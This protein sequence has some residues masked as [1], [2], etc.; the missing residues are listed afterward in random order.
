MDAL[1]TIK[2]KCIDCPL[3]QKECQFLQK[4]GTPKA[5][6]DRFNPTKNKFQTLPFECSL[7]G[8]CSAVCPV[9]LNPAQMFLEMRRIVVRLGGGNFPEYSPLLNYEK[10]GISKRYTY[11][12]FPDHCHTIFFPG[13][14]LAGTRPDK[15]LKVY[16]S[17]QKSIPNL[18]IVLDC[19][20]KP[21][22]DLG[23]ED[24][25]QAMFGEMKSHLV[26]KGIQTVLV[27]CPNCY[28]IFKNHGHPLL[29]RTIYEV[30][31]EI[32]PGST[33]KGLGVVTVHDPCV[34]RFEK[35][36]QDAV[37]ALIQSQGGTI[38]EM[39]HQKAKTICCGEGGAVGFIAPNL[40]ESW[41]VKIKS[42]A[43]GKTILT[44]CAGCANGLNKLTPTH[45]V[46]DFFYE[47]GATLSGKVKISQTLITYWN[48][49]RLKKRFR[50]IIPGGAAR[51]R[52]FQPEK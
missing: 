49:L 12:G 28:Q 13:C 19:C 11:Y 45:H 1:E 22:H 36:I 20:T 32:V 51:E 52:I 34:T 38:E 27:S 23:R 16:E 33:P 7:C 29:V 37:R 46:L 44:Y 50:R 24:Y 30:L 48:R 31:S 18:G 4:Y 17:V 39:E 26:E 5:I 10:R 6:A 9:D 42:E 47:P 2:G 41:G 15:V 43:K 35:P 21:S 25:F 8:L 3:C 40:A 14:A